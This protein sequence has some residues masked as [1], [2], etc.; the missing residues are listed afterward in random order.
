MNT[1]E[2]FL[3]NILK[4]L[5]LCKFKSVIFVKSL[6][7]SEGMFCFQVC[8]FWQVSFECEARRKY[9]KW[10]SCF[11]SEVV[12]DHFRSQVIWFQF[13]LTFLLLPNHHNFFFRNLTMHWPSTCWISLKKT[14]MCI[15][16]SSHIKW[17]FSKD[18]AYQHLHTVNFLTA[19][20]LMT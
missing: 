2:E 20:D 10:S 5:S 16:F 7:V 13:G 6:G 1:T 19:D 12:K 11:R 9:L 15:C 8:Y 18:S 3:E 4:W 14:Q 17:K